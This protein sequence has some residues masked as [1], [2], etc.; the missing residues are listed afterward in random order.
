[1]R[2]GCIRSSISEYQIQGNLKIDLPSLA[3]YISA[4][5]NRIEQVSSRV[6]CNKGPLHPI[7]RLH[8]AVRWLG[9]PCYER[10]LYPRFLRCRAFSTA[11]HDDPQPYE[12]HDLS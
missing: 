2:Y 12:P 1:M 7:Y 9:E 10:L 6:P 3:R 4:M 11:Q 8:A 5:H